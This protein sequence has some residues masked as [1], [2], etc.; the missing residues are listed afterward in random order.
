MGNNRLDQALSLQ[1]LKALAGERAIDLQSVDESGNGDEAVRL[2]ILVKLV[3]SGF[4]EQDGVLCLVLH[5]AL[6]PLQK[7]G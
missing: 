5:L 2:D 6:G 7:P 4:V 1:V 3:G